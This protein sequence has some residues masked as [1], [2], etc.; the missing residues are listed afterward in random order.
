VNGKSS[1][2][3]VDESGQ[4]AFSP[5]SS[6]FFVMSAVVLQGGHSLHQAG[7]VLA[8]IRRDLGR[9][10]EDELHWTNIKTHSQRVRAVQI[11][12]LSSFIT[13]S[14]VVVC[15]R[16]FTLPQP[17]WRNDDDTYL[18]TLSMLLK[19][20]SWIAGTSGTVMSYT[21]AHIVRFKLETLRRHE[22]ALRGTTYE[23]DWS[24]LDPRGG[25]I[26]RP[27]NNGHLQL[28]DL[29]ASAI[30]A[31]FEPDRYG[32]VEPR[33]LLA[34]APRFYR[35]S[36][37]PLTGCGLKLYPEPGGTQEVRAFPWLGELG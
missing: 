9:G 2:A 36:D 24:A 12:G 10:P 20:L 17:Y 16:R 26:D 11:L 27:A 13:M 34:L 25:A 30:A 15:K 3:F 21:L 7:E 8:Q 1:N 31:A 14:T 29:A 4:P 19:R 33:Y 23:I 28:A 32:N 37:L 5:R 18:N 35:R 22:A 6:D